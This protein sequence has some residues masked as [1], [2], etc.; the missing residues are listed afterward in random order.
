METSTDELGHRHSEAGWH[1]RMS[2][3]LA[4]KGACACHLSGFQ[5]PAS[6][7]AP[8]GHRRDDEASAETSCPA[9]GAVMQSNYR[10]ISAAQAFCAVALATACAT[11]AQAADWKFAES[12]SPL[13]GAASFSASLDSTEPLSNMLG[14]PEPATFVMRCS[15][16]Q[17]AAYVVWPQ[18]VVVSANQE[19]TGAPQTMVLWRIDNTDLRANFWNISNAGTAAGKFDTGG[20]VKVL[21]PLAGAHR[22]VVRMTGQTEQDAVFDLGDVDPIIARVEQTC[23]MM[24]AKPR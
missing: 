4:G 15:G 2:S 7:V 5:H 13:T 9:I 23:G 6:A 17:L 22:L 16:G 11:S 24:P 14:R 1:A 12:K 18:V 21:R 3:R 10:F 20:A 19:F 8:R